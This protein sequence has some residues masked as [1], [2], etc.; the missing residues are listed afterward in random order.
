MYR[1]LNVVGIMNSLGIMNYVMI[2]DCVEF[3]TIWWI[4][5]N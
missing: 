5:D 4:V 2:F 1:V 3:M